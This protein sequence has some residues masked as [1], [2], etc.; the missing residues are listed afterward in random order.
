MLTNLVGTGSSSSSS[1]SSS[2]S[3]SSSSSTC[4]CLRGR[5]RP[6]L[7]VT[8]TS[9]SSSSSSSS[10][11]CEEDNYWW[12][13]QDSF[14]EFKPRQSANMGHILFS[15]V[16]TKYKPLRCELFLSVESSEVFLFPA[17]LELSRLLVVAVP[18]PSLPPPLP[19]DPPRLLPRLV[20]QPESAI[21]LGCLHVWTSDLQ[22]ACKYHY[23]TRVSKIYCS[24]QVKKWTSKYN[25]AQMVIQMQIQKCVLHLFLTFRANTNVTHEQDFTC[26]CISCCCC[27]SGSTCWT[28]C[29][30]CCGC[31]TSICCP[32]VPSSGCICR[33]IWPALS[34]SSVTNCS[35]IC[36]PCAV[37]NWP[38]C[39]T[40]IC[41]M[42]WSVMTW[43]VKYL[44][45]YIDLCRSSQ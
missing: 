29:I 41:C 35:W 27:M 36:C 10:S 39:C 34:P 43:N 11:C 5:P 7:G 8:G 14:K 4:C 12:W 25:I 20:R 13:N 17:F 33:K 42:P 19:L 40:T 18:Q 9:S 2:S 22:T 37:R 16:T 15:N 45:Y 28:C 30:I 26:C 6:L 1:P 38:G 44:P 32:D 23:T 24:N 31:C 3:N 21:Q